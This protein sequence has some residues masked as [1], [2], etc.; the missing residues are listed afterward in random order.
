MKLTNALGRQGMVAIEREGPI[1]ED[2]S[3][4]CGR[5]VL[6]TGCSLVL[7]SETLAEE[8]GERA[9]HDVLP[10]AIRSQ[11]RVRQDTPILKPPLARLRQNLKSTD[12]RRPAFSSHYL[13]R[14]HPLPSHPTTEQ[15]RNLVEWRCCER[16]LIYGLKRE[17]LSCFVA[18]WAANPQGQPHGAQEWWPQNAENR[19]QHQAARKLQIAQRRD[20]LLTK[21]L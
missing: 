7:A 16:P 10:A 2:V 18:T 4:F 17:P 9:C 13:V 8:D 15:E 21:P 20:L 11:I 14:G 6:E 1:A 3:E 5:G 19:I 12:R